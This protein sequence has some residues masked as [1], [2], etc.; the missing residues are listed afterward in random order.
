MRP[1]PA[2]VRFI[3][4]ALAVAG[5]VAGCAITPSSTEADARARL[6]RIG[7]AYQPGAARPTPPG[8]R[9]D[10]PPGDFIRFAVL[11]HPAV[12]A[13]Y[14][15]WRAAVE[16]IAP[17][18]A[19]PDPTL[20]FEADIAA[21]IMT[22]MPGVM[23]DFMTPAKRTAMAREAAAS[24]DVAHRAFIVAVFR[25]AAEARKAWAEFAY[26]AEV[27]RL[28]RSTIHAVD[29]AL[30]LANADYPTARGMSVSFERQIRLQN[31]AAQHHAHHAAVA[32]RRAAAR[33]RFKSALGLAPA[34][35]DPPW[36]QPG[37]TVTPL[38]SEDELWRR[39]ATANPELA[40]MRAMV[41][42]A[43]A[44]VEVAR[45]SG[46]PEPTL[47]VMADLRA[48]PVMVRPTA[49]LSLPI[50]R[51]KLTATIAAA[52]ARRD[53]AAARV[54]A[55]QLN[56]AA[57]FAQML[58]MVREADRMLAYLD[59]VALPNLERGLA[60][61]EAGAQS[62]ALGP[63]M[64]SE[65]RLMAIDLRHERVDLLR[66]R[67]LAAIDLALLTADIAPTDSPLLAQSP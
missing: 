37:L 18:R 11:N 45:N 31:L 4:S 60:F 38:P 15:D 65:T 40:K 41:D 43:L 19:L 66:Q 3:V 2:S 63:A 46:N 59:G 24:S 47:G 48:S 42:M 50:W 13:T 49:S 16:A 67:E 39:A 8:L 23:F 62:G 28:Y 21:T 29:E 58:F 34:D 20:T 44:G 57:E 6:Q 1:L 10:S 56:L 22:F 25:T 54:S 5:L 32:D 17:A 64:I 55:E 33:A 30:A 52:E 35:A 36:P 27:D 9:A 14:H 61:A 51:G 53:A 12:A 7:A 26:V